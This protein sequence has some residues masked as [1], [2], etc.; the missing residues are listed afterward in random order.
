VAG[1]RGKGGFLPL[2]CE[3][4][5]SLSLLTSPSFPT[6]LTTH[7]QV[8]ANF[9][10]KIIGTSMVVLV[11]VPEQTAKANLL[12]TAGKA[13]YDATKKAL[14]RRGGGPGEEGR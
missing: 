1:T 4:H 3:A 14:V 6:L 13:K 2:L 10:S 12:V 11:P 8:K 9:S 5:P 7:P